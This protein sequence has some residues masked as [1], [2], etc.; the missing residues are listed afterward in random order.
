MPGFLWFIPGIMGLIHSFGNGRGAAYPLDMARDWHEQ[1]RDLLRA[2]MV[3]AGVTTAELARR[4]GENEKTVF[5]KIR[6][7][8][9]GAA[10]LLQCLALVG[11]RMVVLSEPED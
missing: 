6:Q 10:W 2:E 8:R 5:N 9:F 1:A 4:L 11:A 7:G 3:R